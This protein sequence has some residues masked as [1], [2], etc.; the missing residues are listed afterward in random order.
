MGRGRIT[1]IKN[2]VYTDILFR[3]RDKEVYSLKFL[4]EFKEDWLMDTKSYKSQTVL[5]KQLIILKEEGFVGIKKGERKNVKLFYIKWERIVESFIDYCI[6]YFEE[7][8]RKKRQYKEKIKKLKNQEYRNRLINNI[9]L[10]SIFRAVISRTRPS[11][12]P[13]TLADL[14]ENMLRKNRLKKL[15]DKIFYDKDYFNLGEVRSDYIFEKLL[16]REIGKEKYDDYIIFNDFIN[17]IEIYD[18]YK[19]FFKEIP[20]YIFTYIM[21]KK[22]GEERLK[23]S[24]N[25]IAKELETHEEEGR[26]KTTFEVPLSEEELKI[27][28]EEVK[29]IISSM[30]KIRKSKKINDKKVLGNFLKMI[31]DKFYFIKF[32]DSYYFLNMEK[33]SKAVKSNTYYALNPLRANF[34]LW[35]FELS[36]FYSIPFSDKDRQEIYDSYA[37]NRLYMTPE[38]Y[39]KMKE[40]K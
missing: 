23:K 5:S 39:K 9:F 4:E 7:L 29:K 2:P 32:R 25:A 24:L 31:L 38:E 36:D 19:Y 37:M 13:E 15:H 34:L 26:N 10:K 6:E 17:L 18:P 33:L 28:K 14:F 20:P 12:I 30:E 16:K 40:E 8:N 22:K 11:L 27:T 1:I 3:M 21:G 35:E